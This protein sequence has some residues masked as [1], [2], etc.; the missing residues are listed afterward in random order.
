MLRAFSS[1]GYIFSLSLSDRTEHMVQMSSYVVDG[2][3]DCSSNT[4][5][6]P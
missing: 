2:S 1:A 3:S 4:L 6:K 5:T